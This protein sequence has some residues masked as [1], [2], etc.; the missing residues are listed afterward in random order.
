MSFANTISKFGAVI[1][2]ALAAQVFAPQ[3]LAATHKAWMRTA[4]ADERTEVNQAITDL[5][6]EY[7]LTEKTVTKVFEVI[8]V[9]QYWGAQARIDVGRKLVEM[10]AYARGLLKDQ[11]APGVD[12]ALLA[13][14]AGRFD[15]VLRRLDDMAPIDGRSRTLPDPLW[16]VIVQVRM[17]V[18]TFTADPDGAIAMLQQ[19][20]RSRAD[21]DRKVRYFLAYLE[22]G[23]WYNTGSR[24]AYLKSI[25]VYR[26]DVLPLA[27][28][29]TAPNDW[30]EA[31]VG[32]CSVY[33][34]LART[35]EGESR[36]AEEA[37]AS[38]EAALAVYRRED[39]PDR[40]VMA[41]MFLATAW[42]A[43]GDDSAYIAE[44][45]THY[46]LAY[47]VAGPAGKNNSDYLLTRIADL[48][49]RQNDQSAKR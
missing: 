7:G 6:R 42:E 20:R 45:L 8:D 49:A 12:R 36:Y 32:I 17:L 41:Q 16:G 38:C 2:L 14:D 18:L 40:W 31:Q 34:A 3:A 37:I 30:A 10:A 23:T 25:E 28:R 11:D 39:Q 24:E 15:Q 4:S 22:A 5:A 19:A 27:P 13:F 26:D 48:E 9:P 35:V 44:A 21:A 43:R 46:R 29:E 47:E 33:V 1:V